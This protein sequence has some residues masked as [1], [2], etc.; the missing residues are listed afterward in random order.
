MLRRGDLRIE[1]F[2]VPQATP[3]SPDRRIPDRDVHT[4][5]NK[6][7]AFAIRDV[8]PVEQELRA[9]GGQCGQSDRTRARAGNVGRVSQRGDGRAIE[10]N[11]TSR[12]ISIRTIICIDANNSP[13]TYLPVAAL[14]LYCTSLHVH[15]RAAA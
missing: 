15:H 13:D 14:T 3:M 1:L 6:H 5:G 10:R 9:R 4:H 11:G 12:Q 7:I 8:G 2:E